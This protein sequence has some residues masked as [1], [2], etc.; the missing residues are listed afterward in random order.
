M[1]LN[2][3]IEWTDATWN[4]TTGC[5]KVSPGCD[6]CYAATLAKRLKAMGNR[7]YQIDGP[8][9][10]GFGLSL[11]W[12]KLVEPLSWGRPRRVFVNSMSDLFHPGVPRDFLDR[13]FETM[14]GCPHHEFQILTKRPTRMAREMTRLVAR[15][16]GP[17]SNV[18]LG[19]SIENQEWAGKR[20]PHLLT[21]PAV[22][23]FLS[24]E[25]LIDR[26]TLEPWLDA[27]PGLHWVIV[28]GES[29]PGHRAIDIAWVRQLR[30]E[31]LDAGVPFFFKQWGGITP[32]S[33]GRE[34]DGRTWDQ[35]PQPIRPAS[36]AAG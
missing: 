28:G 30:D 23:R 25:P 6:N 26:V 22:V 18:W 31:C 12:D 17:L 16:G 27:R 13:A 32:K 5:R 36:A 2:S 35:M 10:Q 14:A 1:S 4:P 19:T 29:G 20:I 7:R 3:A 9:G 34:L 21:T 8:D 15:L 33:G 11:H 24:C